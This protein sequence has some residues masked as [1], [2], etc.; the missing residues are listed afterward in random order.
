MLELDSYL[1]KEFIAKE[2]LS[3]SE[4]ASVQFDTKQEVLIQ[5]RTI[6]CV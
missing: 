6:P 4:F 3:I 1:I 5:I 2:R